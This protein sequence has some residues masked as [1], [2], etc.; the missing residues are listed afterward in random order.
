MAVALRETEQCVDFFQQIILRT[1]RQ[2]Q[3]SEAVQQIDVPVLDKNRLT[4]L[5]IINRGLEYE[6]SWPELKALVIA[7]A[8]YMERRGHW[9][10]WRDVLHGAIA[11]AQILNDVDAEITLTALFARLS[12]RQSRGDDVVRYYRR[13]IRL[14][15]RHGNQFEEARACSNLGY[16]YIDAGHWWRSEVLSCHALGLFEGWG[17]E[18][19]RAHR[20]NHLG[21]YL[22][23]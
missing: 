10:A 7:F 4:I 3:T 21:L 6:P 22:F 17:S 16:Y 9:D 15:K 23:I 14:A 2:W 18:H 1:V 5:N 19:R 13:V 20:H 8:S 12:Q 11:V